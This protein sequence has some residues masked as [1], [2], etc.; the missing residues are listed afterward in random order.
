MQIAAVYELSQQTDCG[1]VNF[2]KSRY[3]ISGSVLSDA[4]RGTESVNTEE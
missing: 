4:H 3:K 1:R 2:M